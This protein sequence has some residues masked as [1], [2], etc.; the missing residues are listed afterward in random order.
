VFQDSVLDWWIF[1]FVCLW[2]FCVI[3][4]GLLVDFYCPSDLF[5]LLSIFRE[6]FFF[7][8]VFVNLLILS[9]G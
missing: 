7:W 8:V 1:F 9:D 2:G 4:I 5:I 3:L 6:D